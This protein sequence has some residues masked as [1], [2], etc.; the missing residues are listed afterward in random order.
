MVSWRRDA[1]SW[2]DTVKTPQESRHLEIKTLKTSQ[3]SGIKRSSSPWSCARLAKA[4]RP[5]GCP[6]GVVLS[7][8]QARP[9]SFETSCKDQHS[10]RCQ[11]WRLED[12]CQDSRTPVPLQD[13][14]KSRMLK[15]S[16]R[17]RSTSR[18]LQVQ[19]SRLR[20]INIRLKLQVVA[21]GSRRQLK[22]SVGTCRESRHQYASRFIQVQD[23]IPTSSL[24]DGLKFKIVKPSSFNIPSRAK[25]RQRE[26]QDLSGRLSRIKTSRPTSR[27]L[28][29][30][31]SRA[32]STFKTTTSLRS[33]NLQDTFKTL[34]QDRARPQWETVKTQELKTGRFKTTSSSRCKSRLKSLQDPQVSARNKT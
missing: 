14:G 33:S 6:G 32:S 17:S 4:S 25:S 8:L 2:W 22:T 26:I 19:D 23:S 10:R 12:Y 13:R 1:R 27:R 28:Q 5:L 31:D 24:Q 30:Q 9:S 3:E 16:H 34:P 11:D 7:R 21:Q 20:T 18:R 29:G 15:I